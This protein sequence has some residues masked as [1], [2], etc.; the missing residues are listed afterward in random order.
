MNGCSNRKKKSDGNVAALIILSNYSA[1]ENSKTHT[2]TNTHKKKTQT[3][4]LTK[5]RASSQFNHLIHNTTRG[6]AVD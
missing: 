2:H 6:N 5:S 1:V 3:H 4:T